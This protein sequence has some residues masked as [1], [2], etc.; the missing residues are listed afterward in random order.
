MGKQWKQWQT[1]FFWAP[2]SLQP[3]DQ[4]TFTALKKSY[5]QPRQH[6]TK[7]RHYF[8]NKGP[9]SQSY[10]FSSSH[11]WM[12]ELNN[13]EGWA[14]L[15]ID[16]FETVWRLLRVPWTASRSNQSIL[17]EI[18]PE[19]PLEGLML[20]LHHF[21]HLMQR[22]VSLEKTQMLGKAESRR[23]GRHRKRGLDGIT[24]SMDMN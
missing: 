22:A 21:D 7:Q 19:Y 11:V 15:R 14:P 1:L 3:W 12:W 10:G 24:N 13:Q 20:K 5:E 6:N 17:K 23:R 18:K 4:K 8:A 2:K 16:A 9:S